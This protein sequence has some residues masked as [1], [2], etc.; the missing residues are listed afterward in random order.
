MKHSVVS[1]I[2]IVFASLTVSA[3]A[4]EQKRGGGV[5]KPRIKRIVVDLKDRRLRAYT[6]KGL[7]MEQ[8]VTI[9]KPPD[10]TPQG[11]FMIKYRLQHPWFTPDSD[12]DSEPA[13]PGS[14][15]NPLGSR[16][17][18]F[19]DWPS[20]GIH[21]TNAPEHIG[22][23]ASD[24]CVR[25]RNRDINRLYRHTPPRTPVTIRYRPDNEGNRS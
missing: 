10:S 22:M 16:W 5:E 8:L 18:G 12:S 19:K 9:G 7:F 23:R 14:P 6:Q 13:A 15:D 20:Y 25:M 24:G 11:Q 2:L 4:H 3:A 1:V 21:G 17:M